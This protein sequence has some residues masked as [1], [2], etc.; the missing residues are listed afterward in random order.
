MK[1]THFRLDN[2][3]TSCRGVVY[4]D[5]VL[6][7]FIME[8]PIRDKKISTI[9]GIPA[10]TYG[11]VYQESPTKLT[12]K[13]RAKYSW[14]NKHLMLKDVPGYQSVYIHIGNYPRNTDGCLLINNIAYANDSK[15]L[16]Q[17]TDAYRKFYQKVSA[18]LN[19]GGKVT[20]EIKNTFELIGQE[21]IKETE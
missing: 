2:N 3:A 16:G 9:T 1:I 7:G 6:Y 11:I 18:E 15:M 14:F 21:I 20:I 8:D 12:Q 13:Y 4:I 19:R 10:G 5:P 17:S